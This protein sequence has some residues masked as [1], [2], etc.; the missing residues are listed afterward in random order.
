MLSFLYHCQDF[1]R[2][3]LSIWVTWRVSY[4]KQQLLTFHKHLNSAKLFVEPVLL[5]FFHFFCV[6]LLCVF[7]FLVPCCDVRYDFRRKTMFR[8]SLPPIVCSSAHVLFTLFVFAYVQWC[9]T[10]I[11]LW[12]WFVFI[13]FVRPMLPISLDCPFLIVPSVSSNVYLKMSS[14]T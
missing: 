8:S 9:P 2:I 4:K 14:L 7:T 10:H 11:V 5:I 12:F 1:Y 6:A 13:R 3:W